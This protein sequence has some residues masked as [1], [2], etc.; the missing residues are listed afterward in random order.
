LVAGWLLALAAFAVL[1]GPEALLPG[2]ERYAICLVG[3]AVVLAAR[4]AAVWWGQKSTGKASGT[5]RTAAVVLAL[6]AAWFVAA[7]FHQHYFRFIERT[8][9]CA[10]QTF[11]TAAVEPKR[12]ALDYIMR[13][14]TPGMTWIVA[15]GWWSYW[16]LQYLAAADNDVRVVEADDKASGPALALARTEGR[17][18]YVRFCNGEASPGQQILDYGGRPV[19]CV[20]H[21]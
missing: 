3:P 6:A 11:R 15:D 5:R 13:H 18:W 20:S 7:D 19:L 10:H 9:G 12:A 1:A 17:A 16:P 21:R 14:R 8:G 2:Q 4:G